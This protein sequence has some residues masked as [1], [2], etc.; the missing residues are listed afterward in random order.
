MQLAMLFQYPVSSNSSHQKTRILKVLM[1]TSSSISQTQHSTMLR[2]LWIG[3][4][5][6]TSTPSVSMLSFN[7]VVSALRTGLVVTITTTVLFLGYTLSIQI[8]LPL[9]TQFEC[10]YH[11]KNTYISY[12]FWTTLRDTLILNSMSTISHLTLLL[13]SSLLI[14]YTSSS[15]WM[16][17]SFVISSKHTNDIL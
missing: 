3:Y 13:S 6:L 4:G 10:L 14:Q 16:Q 17:V 11:E 1:K 12:L 15:H 8:T 9:D 5:T 7:N 2:L